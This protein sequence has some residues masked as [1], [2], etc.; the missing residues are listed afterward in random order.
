MLTECPN[1]GSKTPP[2]QVVACAEGITFYN[3]VRCDFSTWN[4]EEYATREEKAK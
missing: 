3:C 4:A 1:C 2:A